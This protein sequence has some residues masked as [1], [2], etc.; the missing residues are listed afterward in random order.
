MA[1]R[2]PFVVYASKSTA[3]DHDS[4]STQLTKCA[5]TVAGQPDDADRFEFAGPFSEEKKSGYKGDRGPELEAALKAVER[6][7]A[8]FG[9]A[10]LWVWKSDRLARGSGKKDEARSLLEVYTRL[11]R[12]GVTIR[13]VLDDLYVQDEAGIGMASK[14]AEKYSADLSE[15]TKAGKQ[16]QYDRGTRPGG[17]VQDGLVLVVERDKQDRIVGR[18][19]EP[20]RDGRAPVIERLFDLA[21]GGNADGTV[22]KQLNREGF[23]KKSGKPWDRRGVQAVIENQGYAGRIVRPAVGDRPAEVIEETNIVPLIAPERYDRIVGLRSKRDRARGSKGRR[24]GRTTTRFVLSKL[25]VCDRCGGRLY[26]VRS[27]YTRRDGTCRRQYI[28]VN[29]RDNTGLCDQPKIDA[30]QVDPAV[31]EHLDRL[32]VDA[33]AWRIEIQT[34]RTAAVTDARSLL[35]EAESELDRLD[36]LAAKVQDD[37]LRQIEA[38]NTDAAQVAADAKAALADQ[39]KVKATEVRTRKAA[40]AELESADADDAMLDVWSD[41]KRAVTTGDESVASLNERLRGE[42]AEF[43]LDWV[44]DGEV[45]V[46]PVLLPRDVPEGNALALFQAW[47]EA[48]EPAPTD[49]EIEDYE[50]HERRGQA[51]SL[52]VVPAQPLLVKKGHD[53]HE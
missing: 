32:F 13:S 11:K 7:A 36:G 16:R 33:E 8:E 52:I 5:R 20:D 22:A 18:T 40:V 9:A 23:R 21:E 39:R 28:C 44:G 25:A 47:K 3:D 14:M 51:E 15:A 24:G 35:G 50:F 12:A 29:V 46:L 34:T 4:I 26:A 1:A 30:E 53:T 42:F 48:G 17:P 41:L 49:A 45:A 19:V 2:L 10:E 38:G 43:R 27:P 31:V 6:A 37:Y